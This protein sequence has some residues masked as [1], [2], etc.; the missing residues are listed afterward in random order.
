M[1]EILAP[2][3]PC[4]TELASITW[5]GPNTFSNRSWQAIVSPNTCYH[6]AYTCSGREHK[7]I[8]YFTPIIIC[9]MLAPQHPVMHFRAKNRITAPWLTNDFLRSI[10]RQHLLYNLWTIEISSKVQPWLHTKNVENGR[11][12]ALCSHNRRSA[13]FLHSRA[14]SWPVT[15]Y[16]WTYVTKNIRMP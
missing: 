16:D 14:F 12:D 3:H 1:P 13:S 8:N 11:A 2:P 7:R 9:L 6:E 5:L 4:V 10:S 15:T